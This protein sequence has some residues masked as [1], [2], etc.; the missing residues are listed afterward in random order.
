MFCQSSFC[1]H[2]SKSQ[3]GV[4]FLTS[5]V[6][7][8]KLIFPVKFHKFLLLFNNILSINRVFTNLKFISFYLFE[9]LKF[10]GCQ[11]Q[12]RIYPMFN[13]EKWPFPLEKIAFSFR[14]NCLFSFSKNCL[15][16]LEKM[17]FSFRKNCLFL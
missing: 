9:I 13:L 16:S 17:P 7:L 12:N 6:V 3:F 2:L 11:I 1:R 10:F 15:F 4:W 8:F 14:Q 5:C